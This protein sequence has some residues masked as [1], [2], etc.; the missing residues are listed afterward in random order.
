[1]TLVRKKKT[2]NPKRRIQ[3]A[4][5]IGVAIIAIVILINYYLDQTKISGQRFGDQLAQIQLDL[6]NETE[7][8]DEKYTS[9]KSGEITK[10]QMIKIAETHIQV[11]KNIMPRYNILQAP[12]SFNPALQL[13]ILSTQTQIDSDEAL[14]EGI[15]SGDNS[16]IAKSD[17]LLQQSFQYEMQAL[18]SYENAK[19]KGSQ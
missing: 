1:M 14:K 3:A 13:F 7:S 6:K 10:E 5:S 9:Y 12:E 4:I 18:Q 15:M 19:S 8:F 2:P 17:H 16:T 11:L